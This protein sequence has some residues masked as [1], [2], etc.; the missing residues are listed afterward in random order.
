VQAHELPVW[1]GERF[2]SSW[3][4]SH[5]SMNFQEGGIEGRERKT[6]KANNA[7]NRPG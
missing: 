2:A 3:Q 4:Q 5:R 7:G 6:G 1:Q